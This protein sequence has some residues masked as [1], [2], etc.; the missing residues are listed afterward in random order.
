MTHC[1]MFNYY[2]RTV[3]TRVQNYSI[4]D[5]LYILCTPCY[6]P[7]KRKKE[8]IVRTFGQFA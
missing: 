8:G 1:D 6:F 3:S 2:L 5:L 7:D 4:Q